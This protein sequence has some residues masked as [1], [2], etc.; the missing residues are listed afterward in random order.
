MV[1]PLMQELLHQIDSDY[2][3]IARL[4]ILRADLE[5][6]RRRSAMADVDIRS[7]IP[8]GMSRSPNSVGRQPYLPTNPADTDPR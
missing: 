5:Q 6:L 3:R 8:L 1:E 7:K 4:L 2:Y